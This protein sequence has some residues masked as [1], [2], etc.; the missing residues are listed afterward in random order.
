MFKNILI[1]MS[2]LLTTA[3]STMAAVTYVPATKLLQITGTTT[4]WQV[5]QVTAIMQAE[6]VRIVQLSGPG[7]DFY[8]GLRLGSAIREEGA[9]VI[10]PTK[11]T[12]ISAC[13]FAA[14]GG[15]DVLVDGKLWFHRPY[16]QSVRT[17]TSSE[18][19]AGLVTGAILDAARYIA[20]MG[21]SL[22]FFTAPLSK[23][24]PCKFY[25]L[26]KGEDLAKGKG[27]AWAEAEAVN[28][29]ILDLCK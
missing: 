4:G 9:T 3:T 21:Y 5:A 2:L 11:K 24:S 8:A 27:E 7:G 13:A 6:D 19:Y 14:L 25:T 17:T 22:Q 12:C 18:D 20:R 1:T 10:I 29:E 28:W 23:S 26:S 16:L 15:S